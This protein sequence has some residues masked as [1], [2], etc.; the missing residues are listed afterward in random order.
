MSIARLTIVASA[1]LALGLYVGVSVTAQSAESEFRSRYLSPGKLFPPVAVSPLATSVIAE[2]AAVFVTDKRWYLV[3]EM[4][5]LNVTPMTQ[6]VDQLDVLTSD[7]VIVA[8]YTGPAAIKA[9]MTD[10]VHT[11]DG[12]DVLPTS[13]GGLL[14]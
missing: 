3:Y 6:R 4:S 12:T 2:P 9:I 5:L 7:G 1:L 11:F 8:S 14:F 10:A 13:G